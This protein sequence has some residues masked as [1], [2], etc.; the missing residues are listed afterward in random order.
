M[1]VIVKL[2]VIMSIIGTALTYT[3]D[4]LAY[5]CA[6]DASYQCQYEAPN[7][8]SQIS[9]VQKY[10]VTASEYIWTYIAPDLSSHGG[11]IEH[12]RV[13]IEPY[14][15]S[16]G[17]YHPMVLAGT[18]WQKYAIH[19]STYFALEL[20]SDNVE[21]PAQ[22]G[23]LNFDYV[24][25]RV[26]HPSSGYNLALSTDETNLICKDNPSKFIATLSS[27][28]DMESGRWGVGANFSAGTP[29]ETWSPISGVQGQNVANSGI[30]SSTPTD[31]Y[32]YV[33]VFPSMENSACEY[34][35]NIVITLTPNL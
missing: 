3:K 1:E 15:S 31:N 17:T 19:V 32:I 5:D 18:S 35:G 22:V 7:L 24:T 25:A 9:V 16:F 8:N 13:T 21:I 12:Y 28:G 20:L 10:N 34:G 26:S 27:S 29:P 14:I 33:G 23:R 6:L 30:A 11:G 4:A 2:A